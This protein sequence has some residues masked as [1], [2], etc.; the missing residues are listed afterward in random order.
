[1]KKRQV[2]TPIPIDKLILKLHKLEAPM[3][4]LEE[5]LNFLS[6]PKR[7]VVTRAINAI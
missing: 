6:E 2:S 1:M 7:T 4:L 5:L 3:D